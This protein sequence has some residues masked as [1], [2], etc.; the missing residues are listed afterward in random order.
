[1]G[2]RIPAWHFVASF[3][4]EPSARQVSITDDMDSIGE[5]LRTARHNKKASLEDVSRATKI[6]IE[7]LEKL[8]ADDFAGLAAPMYTKSFLKMYADYLGADSAGMVEAYLKSQGGLRRQ[9]LQLETEATLRSRRSAE[10][11][12]PVGTV[13]R[14][15]AAISAVA[16]IGF[17][18]Y[19]IWTHRQAFALPEH[20][21][22]ALPVADFEA[23]YQPKTRPAPAVLEAPAK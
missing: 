6:K 1:M 10:L 9:G 21:P 16:V 22:A 8:E 18:G 19:Q 15:V 2:G 5:T 20:K 7:I 4:L 14:V 3:F 12:L 23:Y 13:I 11:E 17:V